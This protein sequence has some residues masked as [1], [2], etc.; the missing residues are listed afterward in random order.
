MARLIKT[1][2]EVEGRREDVWLVVEEDALEQWPAGPLDVV[3]KP[4]PR[5]DGPERA[6]GEATFT[7]DIQLPGMLHAAVLRSPHAHGLP[8]AL[9]AARIAPN[10]ARAAAAASILTQIRLWEGAGG[11]LRSRGSNC[12]VGMQ[13]CRKRCVRAP[14]FL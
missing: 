4:A 1:E 11:P 6:R 12:K 9:A 7:A 5:V 3:G 10:A 2:K 13:L 14:S 8:G